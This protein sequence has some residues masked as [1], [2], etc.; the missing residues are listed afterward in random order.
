V[1][2]LARP[3][4]WS[5]AELVEWHPLVADGP[6]PS[7]PDELVGPARHRNHR[8]RFLSAALALAT[9]AFAAGCGTGTREATTASG[10]R[11]DHTGGNLPTEDNFTIKSI[12]EIDLDKSE[13][14]C[15]VTETLA[16]N[17]HR[18]ARLET[19]DHSDHR[20]EHAKAVPKVWQAH[21][22]AMS[23][24]TGLSLEC[25]YRRCG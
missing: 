18:D 11:A 21:P 10:G 1:A 25:H 14:R 8:T 4:R 23:A 13:G 6:V 12:V 22:D 9:V 3:Q 20:G 15:G 17:L 16:H 24:I 7:G 5:W 19:A 2:A